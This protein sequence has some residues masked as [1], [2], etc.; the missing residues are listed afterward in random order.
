MLLARQCPVLGRDGRSSLHGMLMAEGLLGL[1][2]GGLASS[3][4]KCT[5]QPFDPRHSSSRDPNS[6]QGE[7]AQ[8]LGRRTASRSHPSQG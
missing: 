2:V 4:G 6:C 7:A 1:R 3:A 5:H 8:G